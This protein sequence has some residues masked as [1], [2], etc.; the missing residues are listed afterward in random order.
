MPKSIPSG[1][2]TPSPGRNVIHLMK[3]MLGPL[4]N[5]DS[6]N[7]QGSVVHSANIA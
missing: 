4:H 2:K 5:S 7:R 1:K 6:E 3:R